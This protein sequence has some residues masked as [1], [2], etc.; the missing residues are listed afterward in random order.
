MANRKHLKKDHS[1]NMKKI[2]TKLPTV[3]V[4]ISAFNEEK[5]IVTF[6][7]S[8]LQQK[9]DGF[10]LE[11]IWVYSDGSTDKTVEKIRSLHSP[12]I[13]IIADK[14]RIGKSS[15]LNQIYQRLETDFLVQSDADVIFD[16]LLVIH[17]IIQ[18]LIHDQKV[19]MC[20]GNPQPLPAETFTEKAVNVTFAVY[21]PLRKLGGKHGDNV[22]SVDGRLLAYRREV[23]QK[24]HVPESMI[25]ND[26]FTFYSC[27]SMGFAYKF[28]ESA[29]VWFRSPQTFA[30]QIRQN[31]RFLAAPI[32]MTK[33]FP[34]E[35]VEGE[36]T[37][38]RSAIIK[39]T[40]LQF[41]KHPILC[42]YIFLVNGYCR[43][44]VKKTEKNLTAKWLIAETT[45][46]VQ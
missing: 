5:N 25:A 14:K 36:R 31:T 35:L 22:Y 39:N 38:P 11:K 40:A 24:I 23:I 42:S 43:L 15:R 9:E 46:Q 17:D 45:K 29:V 44:K 1:M 2:P 41:L 19:G 12:K 30:D 28:V 8:V 21:A 27:I 10:I 13:E 4:A 6:L 18:P 37:V 26:A 16:H 32:R 34:A 3:T 20:G 7:Q 33:Y